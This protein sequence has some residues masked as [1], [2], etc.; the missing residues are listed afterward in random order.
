MSSPTN[1]PPPLT[2]TSQFSVAS[3]SRGAQLSGDKI[4]LP[5]STLEQ[6][7]SAAPVTSPEYSSSRSFEPFNPF[8]RDTERFGSGNQIQQPQLPHPLTFRLVNPDNGRVVYAGIR[9]FS[10]EEGE[11]VLSQFLRGSLGVED[12]NEEKRDSGKAGHDQSNDIMTSGVNDFGISK[13]A[14]MITVHA[15]QLPKGKYARLRPLEAGYDPEDWK[16]LLEQHLRRNFT[17]LTNRE[18][19]VVP[20]GHGIGGNNE[21]F[22]FLVDGLKPEGDGICVVDT[23]LEV[24][25][26]A[27]NEEQARETLKKIAAKAHRPRGTVE[28]SSSG[29]SLDL[30]RPAEGQ[31]VGGEYVDYELAS[32]DRSQGLE[33]ELTKVNEEQELDIFLSPFGSR[34]RVKPRLDEH[35]FA[36]VSS[37]SPKRIR[38]RS[39]NAEL[40]HA[41][42]IWISVYAF[43]SNESAEAL[44][45]PRKFTLRV[46]PM[47]TDV[48]GSAS[49]GNP[50]TA[51]PNPS[52]VQC[53]NCLQ[54][55]PQGRLF[56]H[57]NFCLRNNILC[58][59]C[60]RVFQKRSEAWESHWHCQ[61]DGAFGSTPLSRTKHDYYTHTEQTCPSCSRSFSSMFR[62]AAHK[63]TVPQE[64][65]PDV[66]NAEALLSGLTPHELA[67]GARTTEC[68]LCDKIVRMRDMATHLKHHDLE[69][70]S[71]PSPRLCRNVNCGR[72]LDG[73]S[74]SGDTRA[75]TRRGQGPGNDIG[76]CSVCFGPLYVSMYDPDGRALRRRVERRYLTQLLTGCGKGW[77][78]NEYC[79]KGR[80]N[81][82]IGN[83]AVATRDALPMIR[84]FLDALNTTEGHV[85]PLHFCVDEANQKRRNLASMM[86]AEKGMAGKGGY[87]IEWCVAALEAEG[88]DLDNAWQWLKNWA[89]ERAETH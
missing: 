55:V 4:V 29:G 24:D 21:E 40:D 38:L 61:Y 37:E 13:A 54:W 85:T 33:V 15:K 65:D 39:T 42:T 57:E 25:I 16:S 67:D 3:S 64:G 1:A 18:V 8:V 84:P 70:F 9:E 58:P 73:A 79:R 48:V 31:V 28:G 35:V 5:H 77:C 89:P 62:L 14:Q 74:K 6:L 87:D 76:L 80:E 20:G 63:T 46:R 26:E 10:A 36:E 32:W 30:F 60:L 59:K 19:L 44:V 22:R 81:A 69:R 88:G 2:W 43:P 12:E 56:L 50:E 41:E 23:D 78:L 86:A 83:A 71:R 27:L 17:T 49:E 52:D 45:V 47:D 51:P 7:L 72:T 11:I 75:G 34:Q 66:P 82:G 53:K 68:H